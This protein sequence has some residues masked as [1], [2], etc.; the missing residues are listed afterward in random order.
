MN[1]GVVGFSNRARITLVPSLMKHAERMNFDIIGVSDLWNKRR[2][3]GAKFLN[4][5]TGHKARTYRNND[6]LYKDK[7]IDAVVI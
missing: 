7:D 4:V 3:L 6:E 1:V 5:Q 2:E